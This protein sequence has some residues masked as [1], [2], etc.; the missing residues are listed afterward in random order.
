M[1]IKKCTFLDIDKTCAISI[2]NSLIPG[3]QYILPEFI[4]DFLNV[5]KADEIED[6]QGNPPFY[7][8]LVD[9]YSNN[10]KIGSKVRSILIQIISEKK[11]TI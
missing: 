5:L 9:S 6:D 3:Y 11:S 7:T 8:F 1:K 10:D 4:D 2:L